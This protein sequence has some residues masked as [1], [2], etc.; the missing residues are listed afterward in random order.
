MNVLSLIWMELIQDYQLFMTVKV[1]FV[2]VMKK[3]SLI[4]Q[5]VNGIIITVV[6]MKILLFIVVYM[7]KNMLDQMVNGLVCLHST[8]LNFLKM[9]KC[10]LV[11][12]YSMEVITIGELCV[13]TS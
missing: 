5:E 8:S 9:D 10:L 12:S 11:L 13:M 6:I 1:E 4:A 3:D 7:N 2:Q